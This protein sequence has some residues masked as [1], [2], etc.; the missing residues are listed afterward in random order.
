MRTIL[1][2]LVK[3]PSAMRKTWVRSLGWEDPLEKGKK[4]PTPVFWPGESH[5][6]YSPWGHKES[7][8]TDRLSLHFTSLSSNR[9]QLW[10]RSKHCGLRLNTR[11]RTEHYFCAALPA[12]TGSPHRFRRKYQASCGAFHAK[13]WLV[14]FYCAKIRDVKVG[15]PGAPVVG[16]LPCNAGDTGLIPGLGRSHMPGGY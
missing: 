5:G 12:K 1:A 4:L 11:K 16:S 10:E 3:N 9:Q 15:F 7:D 13:D 2:Q 14:N 6:L 8:T